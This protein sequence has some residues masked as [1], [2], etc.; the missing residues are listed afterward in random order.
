MITNSTT[1]LPSHIND[2]GSFTFHYIIWPYACLFLIV[3]LVWFSIY[4][5]I[6][7]S[8]RHPSK[9]RGHRLSSIYLTRYSTAVIDEGVSVYEDPTIMTSVD[10]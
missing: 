1:L 6:L 2:K 5:S 3:A 9:T 4:L 8:R 10:V 7:Y